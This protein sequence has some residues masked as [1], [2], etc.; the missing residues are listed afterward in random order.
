MNYINKILTDC[1]LFNNH[2]HS[3]NRGNFRVCANLTELCTETKCNNF[4][5]VNS[6]VSNKNVFRGMHF[7]KAPYEQA[8]FVYVLEG[9]VIDFVMDIRVN[10]ENYGK[11][12]TIPLSKSNGNCLYVPRGF[13]HGF[14]SLT[15]NTIF[16][17]LVDNTYSLNHESGFNYKNTVISEIILKMKIKPIISS[18]DSLLPEFNI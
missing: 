17:Y 7:Q 8:K 6:S 12:A 18:K 11:I 10:S 15:N 9:E 13:A 1:I 3:D 5:Q 14:L 4:T 2:I 16:C